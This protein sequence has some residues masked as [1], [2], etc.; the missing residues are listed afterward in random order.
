MDGTLT[1]RIVPIERAHREAARDV[2]FAVAYEFFGEGEPFEAWR[3]RVSQSWL[4]PDAQAF[5]IY[6]PQKGGAFW[7]L[8]DGEEVVGTCGVRPLEPSVCELK[9]MYLLPRVRGLG[10]GRQMAL[11]AL[12]WARAS[13]FQFMRLDT[14]AVLTSAIALYRSLG[15][16]P[17][18]RY[19]QS[20]ADL[21]FE[22]K[23]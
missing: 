19:N 20:G 8:L 22:L 10:W 6:Y 2:A 23:L 4:A 12:D 13:G 7:V 9:R 14:D 21:F 16:E 17:I 11:V 1:P 15:F 5:D 18:A 3:E